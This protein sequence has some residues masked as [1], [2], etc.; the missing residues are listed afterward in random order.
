METRE[1][2]NEEKIEFL[3]DT[4]IRIEKE[5]NR[6]DMFLCIELKRWY[7]K[8]IDN[9]CDNFNEYIAYALFMKKIDKIR[10]YAICAWHQKLPKANILRIQFC[11]QLLKF[12]IKK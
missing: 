8:H 4:I 11:E 2:T 6:D 10:G 7:K 12:E 5:K 9:I 3:R 1:F